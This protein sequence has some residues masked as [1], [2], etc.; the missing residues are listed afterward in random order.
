M[1]T[2]R[3][4]FPMARWSP[5]A[6][7]SKCQR[8]AHT[9]YRPGWNP[10][11]PMPR[12]AGIGPPVSV[13]EMEMLKLQVPISDELIRIVTTTAERLWPGQGRRAVSRLTRDAIRRYGRYVDGAARGRS[14]R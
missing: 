6:T 3:R 1:E 2:I 4:R 9:L 14:K 13:V 12:Q 10:A 11:T 7:S 5:K 8:T